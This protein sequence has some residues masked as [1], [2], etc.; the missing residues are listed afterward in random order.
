M[1]YV[2][3]QYGM[4]VFLVAIVV[5]LLIK[6]SGLLGKTKELEERV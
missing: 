4:V 3:T 1:K 5:I 2:G 6:P